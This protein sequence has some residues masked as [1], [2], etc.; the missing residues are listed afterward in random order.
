MKPPSK[1]PGV[2]TRAWKISVPLELNTDKN[3]RLMEYECQ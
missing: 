1:I 3:A 2:F